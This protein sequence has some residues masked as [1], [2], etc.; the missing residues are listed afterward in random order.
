MPFD[1]STLTRSVPTRAQHRHRIDALAGLAHGLDLKFARA[2]LREALDHYRRAQRRERAGES[3][4]N[5]GP[6]SSYRR[7]VRNAVERLRGLED[8]IIRRWA[9]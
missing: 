9:S 1:G 5:A 8:Q 2:N 6:L 7:D 4:L 3:W